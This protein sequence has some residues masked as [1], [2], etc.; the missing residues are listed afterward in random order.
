M[1]L[2]VHAASGVR[3]LCPGGRIDGPRLLVI[4]SQD[5]PRWPP[6]EGEIRTVAHG[7]A[8][9]LRMDYF[10]SLGLTGVSD[11]PSVIRCT[12]AFAPDREPQVAERHGLHWFD[13]AGH[14]YPLA[15][16]SAVGPDHESGHPTR[17][18]KTTFVTLRRS[19]AR[20]VPSAYDFGDTR[21]QNSSKS[22]VSKNATAF[23]TCPSLICKYQE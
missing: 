7:G 9:W 10:R 8:R 22:L 23:M 16:A 19:H 15:R 18:S 13:V 11:R 12:A 17:S 5:T 6:R 20:A 21:F 3:R 4:L 14:H 2:A 1:R